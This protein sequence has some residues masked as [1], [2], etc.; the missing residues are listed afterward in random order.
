MRATAAHAQALIKEADAAIEAIE[1]AAP[2]TEYLHDLV[3]MRV[4]ESLEVIFDRV[5]HLE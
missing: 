2:A 4:T 5:K 1:L 3:R